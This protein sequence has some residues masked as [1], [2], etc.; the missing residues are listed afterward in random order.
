MLREHQFNLKGGGAMVFFEVKIF[1]LLRG[2]AEKLFRDIFFRIFSSAHVRDRK[3]IPSNLL[4]G[5]VCHSPPPFKL[6]GCSQRKHYN[7]LVLVLAK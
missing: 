6:N 1:F 2:A 4:T 7:V 5:I 3:K